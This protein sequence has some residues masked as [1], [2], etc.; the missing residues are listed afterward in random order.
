MG[1]C[2]KNNPKKNPASPPTRTKPVTL[3]PQPQVNLIL[4]HSQQQIILIQWGTH[5]SW[6]TLIHKHHKAMHHLILDTLLMDTA[7]T[8]IL[9]HQHN[10][11]SDAIRPLFILS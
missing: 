5:P 7:P 1:L 10:P 3:T 11:M 8:L 9:K 6:G 4:S 2:T